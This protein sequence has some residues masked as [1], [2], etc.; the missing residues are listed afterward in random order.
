MA[1]NDTATA[2]SIAKLDAKLNAICSKQSEMLQ[3]LR[4]LQGEM[5]SH[6]T[7][8]AT[9]TQWISSHGDAHRVVDKQ[10]DNLSSKLSVATTINA[11]LSAALSAIAGII[12]YNR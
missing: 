5:H 1:D 3:I 8:L 9:H 7:E 10:I 6:G 2:V 4:S 12:G 11:A